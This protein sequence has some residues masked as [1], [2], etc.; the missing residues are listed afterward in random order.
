VPDER[1]ALTLALSRALA[2]EADLIRASYDLIDAM[3]GA[4]T[5]ELEMDLAGSL[6]SMRMTMHRVYDQ[7]MAE[8]APVEQQPAGPAEA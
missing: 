5:T 8:L 7:V 2:A 4:G 1:R 6:D 3:H